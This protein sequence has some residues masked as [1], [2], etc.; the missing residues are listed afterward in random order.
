MI[1]VVATVLCQPGRRDDFLKEFQAIVPLVRAEDGCVEYGP[2]V[3]ASTDI[4]A[5]D[6]NPDRVTICEKW[7][8]LSALQAHLT[9]P[10]MLQY[11]PKVQNLVVSTELRIL[12]SV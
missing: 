2:A 12:E 9:A 1:I 8:S 7:E 10:H 3:D 11:R 5:Q 6:T 4:S